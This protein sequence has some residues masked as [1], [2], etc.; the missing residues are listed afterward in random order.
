[1]CI[2]V[3]TG[4]S[5]MYIEKQ[6][7]IEQFRGLDETNVSQQKCIPDN[8]GSQR[9]YITKIKFSRNLR[10][11]KVALLLIGERRDKLLEYL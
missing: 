9:S 4:N 6:Q 8:R 7:Q 11:G 10:N 1:M 2:T 5:S 3:G